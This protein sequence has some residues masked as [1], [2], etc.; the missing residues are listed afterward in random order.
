VYAASEPI[1]KRR[2]A[3]SVQ[4]HSLDFSQWPPH[5]HSTSSTYS[6]SSRMTVPL[7]ASWLTQPAAKRTRSAP[8]SFGRSSNDSTY[9]AERPS[10]LKTAHAS[11][12]HTSPHLATPRA[13][14]TCGHHQTAASCWSCCPA[15]GRGGWVGDWFGWVG[16]HLSADL[17]DTELGRV[18]RKTCPDHRLCHAGVGPDHRLFHRCRRRLLYNAAVPLH[19]HTSTPKR[20]Q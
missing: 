17:Q 6:T 11:W 14:P 13:P 1:A 15:V 12:G 16:R 8:C 7:L 5:A 2:R 9:E 4:T 18:Y 20:E 3:P 19:N 10:T